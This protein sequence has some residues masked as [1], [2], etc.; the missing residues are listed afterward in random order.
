V[1]SSSLREPRLER[2]K[3]SMQAFE[4]DGHRLDNLLTP[5]IQ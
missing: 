4:S 1:E 2:G 3:N 5:M